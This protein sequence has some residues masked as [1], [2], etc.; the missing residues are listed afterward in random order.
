MHLA[1]DAQDIFC[2]AVGLDFRVFVR[3]TRDYDTATKDLLKFAPAPGF[4]R[5][6]RNSYARSA[7]FDPAGPL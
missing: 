3:V 2:N 4:L 1:L 5:L 7:T 6:L